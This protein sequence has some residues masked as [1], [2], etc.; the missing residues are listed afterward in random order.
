M[1]VREHA[2]P[3]KKR[4]VEVSSKQ[5]YKYASAS[6]IRRVFQAQSEGSLIEGLT[7]LRNQLTI[8]PNESPLL[9]TDERL[10]LAKAWL[11]VDPGVHDLFAAWEGT[12]SRQMSLLSVILGVFAAVLNLLSSHYTFH[13]YAQPILRTILSPQ[14]TQQLNTYLAGQHTDLVLV[15][16]KLFNS[17]SGFA[18][19]RER[20]A[21]LDAFAWEMKSLP[22]LLHMR[23]KSKGGE[24]VDMLARPDIRTLY[25]LLILSFMDNTTPAPIKAAFLEQHRDAFTSV[26]KGLWQDSY[27]V[28]RRVLE[29]CWSGLWS[30][31]KLKRTLKIH[32]F[33][34]TTLSQLLRIYERNV[35]EG[36]DSDSVP[37][38]VVHHF[39]LA[40]CTRPGAGLCFHDRGWYPRETDEDHIVGVVPGEGNHTD[41]PHKGSKIY[42]KIL[43]NVL[44]TL[45]VN[46]D[47]RQQELALKILAACPE[48]VSGY[49]SSCSLALEPR[50]SSKWLANIAFFGTV[51]SLPVP[52]ASFVLP[53]SGS[54]STSLYQPAPPPL[55]TVVDN[56]LPTAHIKT[57]L[58]RGLQA[59]SPL[60]QHAAALALAKCLLKYDQVVS[61]FEAVERALEE[62]E[63]D[64][65][66]GLRRR[67]VE[68]EMRRR[69]PEF[70]VVVGFSQRLNETSPSTVE[71]QAKQKEVT[72]APNPTKNALL[73]ESAHRLL[74]LYHRLLPSLVA[75]AR[76]DAGKLL[77]A[78]EDMF[79][80]TALSSATNGLDTLRQLHI[81]RLLKESE[82]FT[83]SGKS[84]S[85]HS[86]FHVLLKA[87]IV[88]PVPAVRSAI[89]ALLRHIL[90]PG[91]L[92]QHDPDEISLWLDSLPLTRRAPGT[93]A[94]DGAPLTDEGDSVIPFLD[95]CVQRCVKTPYK[96]VEELQAL[97]SAHHAL[98]PGMR[99]RGE[100]QTAVSSASSIGQRPEVFPSPLLTTVVEQLGAKLKGKLLSPSDAL[101]LFSFVRQLL[102]RLA[103]KSA[104]LVLCKALLGR[105]SMLVEGQTHFPEY[106]VIEGAIRREVALLTSSIKQLQHPVAVTPP[107]TSTPAVPEYLDRLEQYAKSETDNERQ[108]AAYEVVDWVRLTGPSIATPELARLA[109]VVLKL[110]GPALKDLSRYLDPTQVS[111]WQARESLSDLI[112]ELG[113][114]TLLLHCTN[115]IIAE[116][117]AKEALVDSLF[118][119]KPDNVQLKR[120]IR[121]ILHRLSYLGVEDLAVR[122]WLLVLAAIVRR[123]Q[124]NGYGCVSELVL[125]CFDSEAMR[126]VGSRS[127]TEVVRE[128]LRLLLNNAFM[129]GGEHVAELFAR[130]SGRWSLLL[131]ES[132]DNVSEDERATASIWFQYLTADD[133]IDLLAYLAERGE[134]SSSVTCQDIICE[135]L[136]ATSKTISRDMDAPTKALPLLCRLQSLVP[137]SSE[138]T[139][140]IAAG[141]RNSLPLCHDGSLPERSF[142]DW[143]V[144]NLVSSSV[145]RWSLRLQP[146]PHLSVTGLLQNDGSSVDIVTSLLYRQPS[147]RPAVASWL[148]SP[149]G[150]DC[151]IAYL[152]RILF[153][154]YDTSRGERTFDGLDAMQVHF[155][156]LAKAALDRRQPPEIRSK[157]ADCV[158]WIVSSSRS[159]RSQYLNQL[160][161]DL[162]SVAP[163]KLSS[164]SFTIARKIHKEIG[165]EAIRLAETLLDLGLKWTVRYFV[166]GGPSTEDSRSMLFSL[167][168]LVQAKISVKN[169]LAEPVIA[170]VIQDRLESV[171]GVRF[172]C[173]LASSTQ[174][175]PATVNKFLQMVVQHTRFY[176]LCAIPASLDSATPREDIVDFLCTL[177]HLHPTNTCQASHIEPLHRVYGGTVSAADLKLLSILQLFEATRKISVTSL[178]A[179]W[180]TSPEVS[181]SNALEAIQSLDPG[182]VL[183]TC[184]EYPDWRTFET[185]N[186]DA[187]TASGDSVYDPAF[188]L[189]LLTQVLANDSP[190]SAL[191]WVQL[192]RT[193]V[194]SLILRTL[195]A[196][197][198][199]LREA[200]WA[201]VAALYR[202]LENADLQEKAHVFHI[203]NLLK[204][205][206]ASA[207]PDEPPR[208]PAYTTLLLAH[209]FRGIFYPSNFIYP[210]TARFLLQR[211]TL[212]PS[213]VPM[214][215]A[216]LY[217]SSDDWKKERAWIVR[218]LG[219]GIVA[220]EEW[221]ILKGRHTW[222]LLA[223]L[224]QSEQRDRTLRRSVL[225]VLANITCNARA[226]SSLILRHAL[227][228]WIEMQLPTMHG[229]ESLAWA[230][231]LENILAVVDASKIEAVTNGEWRTIAARCLH[232]ILYHQTCTA[233]V[234]VVVVSVLLRLCLLPGGPSSRIPALL[235][236]S[237]R[238]LAQ[239]EADVAIP[240]SGSYVPPFQTANDL[241][242]R[243][244][245]HR[246]HNLYDL[247]PLPS[248]KQWGECV[249]ALWRVTMTMLDR[250]GE[251]DAL[252]SRLL[253]W[254]AI[255]GVE[256]SRMGE[257]MREEVVQHLGEDCPE[258]NL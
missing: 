81:L 255:A 167:S 28:I 113:F 69:V 97:H 134:R 27:S 88:T 75:E 233:A 163:D 25:I 122:E 209:A 210:L 101:A 95:D 35:S 189:L 107:P 139:D 181:S 20:K 48:L 39:L 237:L 32:V 164:Y 19:G 152:V 251:W 44:K 242:T 162:S 200:A 188:V 94:P 41:A 173:M 235:T 26:F 74:W 208:L 49:W 98:E 192:F 190:Q 153:T 82:H 148:G 247:P 90:S 86:N 240:T 203:L 61:A 127:L 221:R 150:R 78:I 250:T 177:F 165:E 225:E 147:S 12:N 157:A 65:L 55:S 133:I 186:R 130:L 29:V 234:S 63:D 57:H 232:T 116:E 238:W 24:D 6:D 76:F 54:G 102:L 249:E 154:L 194:V 137:Q 169:H 185:R 227:L 11:D 17:L 176:N 171:E 145:K 18:G 92:F 121:L 187:S 77:Q 258:S 64:G 9:V 99:E 53:Q 216:M 253:I 198:A 217:S 228:S 10:L 115:K 34:E 119:S 226:T 160:V 204:D 212:D 36:A 257:W 218:F 30:D 45:K 14:W 5:T 42:N 191:V 8:K 236:R 123:A 179:Q 219:D 46:E 196:K 70:Q 33:N 106:A 118:E 114:D 206:L 109:V 3:H 7:A 104:D 103:S 182:R 58:S 84:G 112:Q 132:L 15:T 149:A 168:A 120:A 143:S 37:A 108:L 125:F 105:I 144:A 215:Y 151:D 159:S 96:Y 245:L 43:A 100:H 205:L 201:Q 146:M 243:V 87:Y 38:D 252:T 223:S 161:K 4:K 174:F 254:R 142:S 126:S 68:R 180:S 241:D 156:R 141:S 197:D 207:P 89:V 175:K 52:S 138:L 62:D 211:Q 22:K 256:G 91:V 31:A 71:G 131:R 128:G 248:I 110:C 158:V 73:A 202:V 220:N 231:I 66:W 244:V 178:L 136:E 129:V 172:I 193:N 199:R 230:R 246:S 140:L 83:W 224:F 155:S 21:V 170:A 111:V 183:R 67:E 13:A 16:L 195:S 239:M 124:E 117:S 222:D 60:V 47:P 23:R 85:K 229:D 51:V 50:L 184:L 59:A 1:P 56:I 93:R 213:D 80:Q 79:L 214:L 2:P 72:S 135:V 166:D 40:V